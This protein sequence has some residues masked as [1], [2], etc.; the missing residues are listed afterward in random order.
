MKPENVRAGK[1]NIGKDDIGSKSA[2][3]TDIER[4]ALEVNAYD[5]RAVC[6]KLEEQLVVLRIVSVQSRL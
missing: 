6:S 1:T 4:G 2:L 5:E 3:E